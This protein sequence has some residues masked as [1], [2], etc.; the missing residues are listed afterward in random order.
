[1][2]D[3]GNDNFRNDD[4]EPW[5]AEN[6]NFLRSED[7]QY[8]AGAVQYLKD[9]HRPMS[10]VVGDGEVS[11]PSLLISIGDGSLQSNFN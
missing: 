3:R 2:S 6:K 9:N 11:Q 8:I 1:M 7:H 5:L 10:L 4:Q